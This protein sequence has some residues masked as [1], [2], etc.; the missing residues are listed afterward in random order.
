[1]DTLRLALRLLE[2]EERLRPGAGWH[3]SPEELTAYHDGRLSKRS[4]A[5]V[6]RHLGVCFDCPDLLLEL[7]RFLGP[8]PA[9]TGTADTTAS[10][11]ELRRRLF[12]QPRPRA[13]QGSPAW[14]LPSDFASL[15]VAY[16]LA[17]ASLLAAVALSVWSL[18]P[19]AIP[20]LPMAVVVMPGV[21]RGLEPPQEI[22]VPP[23]GIVL[24]LD[25]ARLRSETGLRLEILDPSGRRIGAVDGLRSDSDLVRALLPRSLL[26]AGELRLRLTGRGAAEEVILRVL[27]L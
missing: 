8:L 10:W 4:T 23:A 9:E 22:R 15:R 21:R 13:W 1:M 25:P 18:S 7:E 16:T 11:Q 14:R 12:A 19:H 3:P 27:H 17:A 20:N 2:R 26:P 6:C 24:I 5:R